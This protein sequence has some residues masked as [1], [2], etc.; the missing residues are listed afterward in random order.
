MEI[1]LNVG[2]LPIAQFTSGPQTR[3]SS[4]HSMVRLGVAHG[5]DGCKGA[6]LQIVRELVHVYMYL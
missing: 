4:R 5:G 1:G 2:I 3:T 6:L